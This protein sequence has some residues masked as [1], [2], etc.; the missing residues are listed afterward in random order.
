MTKLSKI[1][2]CICLS[3]ICICGVVC[4]T[5]C[6]VNYSIELVNEFPSNA[7]FYNLSN[8]Q[9][10]KLKNFEISISSRSLS[11]KSVFYT[12]SLQHFTG[13]TNNQIIEDNY[14]LNI[15]GGNKI[16]NVLSSYQIKKFDDHVEI[17]LLTW[18]ISNL[19]GFEITLNSLNSLFFTFHIIPSGILKS[20]LKYD[21]CWAYGLWNFSY[22]I[23]FNN[24]FYYNDTFCFANS[25]TITSGIGSDFFQFPYYYEFNKNITLFD[26]LKNKYSVNF[27]NPNNALTSKYIKF[28]NRYNTDLYIDR[29]S[30]SVFT[31]PLELGDNL[32]FR[33]GRLYLDYRLKFLSDDL[34]PVPFYSSNTVNNND[35]S[36]SSL[37]IGSN[38]Y[39]KTA[40]WYDIPTH[41][42]NFFIYLIFDAPIVSNF[43]K[44]AMV[45]INFLVETFNF[46]IGLFDGVSNVFFIS[47]FVGMLALIFLLKIIF[48]GK[49]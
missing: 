30:T 23:E 29:V 41:L 5:Y 49:T 27:D 28:I 18:S 2:L 21:Y 45:I 16:L 40:A 39:Y 7:N 6:D 38:S 20:N 12:N 32:S 37:P 31:G 9:Y 48:G 19:D 14:E 24:Q 4:Y 25:S 26:N 35:N 36:S 17:H 46:V 3:I 43:T 1:L 15:N 10:I 8:I 33:G 11:D 13:Y 42:Y 44:L 22:D 47:I 34:S